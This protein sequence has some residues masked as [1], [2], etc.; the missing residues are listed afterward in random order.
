MASERGG[1]TRD[2]EPAERHDGGDCDARVVADPQDVST[3][4]AIRAIV[5]RYRET[6]ERLGR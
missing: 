1:D 3:R 4:E 5:E 6:F 2:D